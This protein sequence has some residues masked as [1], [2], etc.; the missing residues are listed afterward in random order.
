MTIK[1]NLVPS[2]VCEIAL[3]CN[4]TIAVD[5]L[6]RGASASRSRDRDRDSRRALSARSDRTSWLRGGRGRRNR[7]SH[8]RG[9]R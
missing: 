5:L 2:G 6:A 9:L 8:G 7:C 1:G 3:P 4:N